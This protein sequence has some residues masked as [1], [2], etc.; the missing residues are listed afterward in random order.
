MSQTTK[1]TKTQKRPRIKKN[2]IDSKIYDVLRE[3]YGSYKAEKKYRYIMLKTEMNT[4]SH[5]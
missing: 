2:S 3:L 5:I 1:N 4:F